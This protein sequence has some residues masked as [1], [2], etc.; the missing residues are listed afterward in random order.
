MEM[1]LG[2]GTNW[3]EWEGMEMLQ[4]IPAHLFSLPATRKSQVQ[5]PNHYSTEPT[6]R[7]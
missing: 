3:W 1:G 4:A 7:F 5:S 6:I 2:M